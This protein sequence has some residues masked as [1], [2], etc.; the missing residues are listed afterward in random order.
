MGMNGIVRTL[1]ACAIVFAAL[2]WGVGA[3]HWF[4]FSRSF[5][6]CGQVVD[7]NGVPMGGVT[8]EVRVNETDNLTMGKYTSVYMKSS[9]DGSFH[10]TR[11]G[12]ASTHLLLWKDDYKEQWRDYYKGG[13]Y[14]DV[15]IVLQKH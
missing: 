5:T 3:R 10:V 4:L 11:K 6:I 7:A 8:I 14:S 12:C 15:R 9:D 2:W 13:T 1:F